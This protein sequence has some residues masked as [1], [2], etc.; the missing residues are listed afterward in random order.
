[1]RE[2]DVFYHEAVR[3]SLLF[4]SYQEVFLRE[5]SLSLRLLPAEGEP[6]PEADA[7]N[8]V[9]R[10]RALDPVISGRCNEVRRALQQRVRDTVSTQGIRCHAGLREFA[11]PILAAGR[12]VSTLVAG[13]VL[14]HAWSEL[15]LSRVKEFCK[16]SSCEPL[17]EDLRDAYGQTPRV[18]PGKLRYMLQ[19]LELVAHHLGLHAD[20]LPMMTSQGEPPLVRRMKELVAADLSILLSV[21]SISKG[22]HCS[23]DYLERVFKKHTGRK[24][25]DFFKLARMERADQLLTGC[26]SKIAAVAF[27]AG[28]GS[29]S[30]FNR[31]FKAFTGYTPKQWRLKS[32]AGDRGRQASDALGSQVFAHLARALRTGPRA[33]SPPENPK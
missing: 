7:S 28:F 16:G 5:H 12:H 26:K 19:N 29:V 1:V 25:G 14:D 13:S 23:P 20:K 21:K 6:A 10:L 30:Q 18:A 24:V 22:L 3:E 27:E 33:A 9:C 11:V 4:Q 32:R 2:T 8:T 17:E 31:T 15:D